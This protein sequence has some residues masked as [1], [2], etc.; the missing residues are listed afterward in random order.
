MNFSTQQC[1]FNI[2]PEVF[3]ILDTDAEL[4]KARNHASR[5]SVFGTDMWLIERAFNERFNATKA[6]GS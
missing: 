2:G 5:H 4:N 6:G 1:A 3:N